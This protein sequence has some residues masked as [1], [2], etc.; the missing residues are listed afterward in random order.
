VLR[1]QSAQ[2]PDYTIHLWEGIYVTRTQQHANNPEYN[3]HLGPVLV[4]SFR[5]HLEFES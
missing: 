1:L 3:R 4:P 2:N 5:L